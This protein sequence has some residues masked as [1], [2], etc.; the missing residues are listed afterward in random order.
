MYGVAVPARFSCGPSRR[1]RRSPHLTGLPTHDTLQRWVR[2]GRAGIPP[3][4]LDIAADLS[5]LRAAMDAAY[6]GPPAERPA[7]KRTKGEPWPRLRPAEAVDAGI[8]F[9]EL[10]RQGVREALFDS[11]AGVYLPQRAALGG[12][13]NLPVGWYGNQDAAWIAYFDVIRRLGLARFPHGR[14]FDRWVTLARSAGWWWPAEDRCVLV[15]RP[16]VLRT[17]PV[18]GGRHDEVRLCAAD[19]KPGV[20]YRDG[21]ST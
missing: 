11:L 7:A 15:E 1:V 4:A 13:A 14:V 5:Q 16:V 19:G 3:V 2:T 20:R 6:D 17:E 10:L 12:T 21:W 8:P 18:P 9:Q